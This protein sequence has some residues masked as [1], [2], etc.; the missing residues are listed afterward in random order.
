MEFKIRD[1]KLIVVIE[2]ENIPCKIS[3]RWMTEHFTDEKSTFFK[4]MA[5][6]RDTDIYVAIVQFYNDFSLAVSCLNNV[7]YLIF[8]NNQLTVLEQYFKI[9]LLCKTWGYYNKFDSTK[10]IG[11]YYWY[12]KKQQSGYMEHG[13]KDIAFYVKKHLAPR[14][15]CYDFPL[16][17]D[18]TLWPPAYVRVVYT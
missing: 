18:K 5:W 9:L 13:L 16:V 2:S 4:I 3:P 7:N 1:Y 11:A 8:Y 10:S 6:C 15:V 12:V 14:A 17:R